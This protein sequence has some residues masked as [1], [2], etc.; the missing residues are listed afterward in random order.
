MVEIRGKA[1]GLATRITFALLSAVMVPLCFPPFGFW[2]L[3]LAVFALLLLAIRG[4]TPRQAFYLGMIHGTVGYGIA[5]HWFVFIFSALAFPLFG[6][7]GLFSAL[8][9]TLY[10]FVS[11]HAKNDGSKI[12]IAAVLWTGIEFYRSELFMLRFPWLTAGSALGPTFL[13]PILG[14]HGAT[15]LI[16]TAAAAFM[17]RTTLPLAF[18]LSLGVACLGIFRPGRVEPP[19]DA[20]TVAVVQSEECRLDSYLLLT[21]SLKEASPDLVIWPEY[22]LPYDVRRKPEHYVALKSLC[23]ELNT[24]LVVGTQTVLDSAEGGWHNTALTLD[25]GGTLGEYYKARPVHFFND[26]IPGRD[27]TPVQTPLGA[28]GTPICFDCDYSAVARKMA[29]LGAEFYAVPSFDAA[30]WS[31]YQHWQHAAMFRLRTAENG[32]WLACAASS[33]VSQIIDP[34][35]HVHSSLP[36]METGVIGCRIGRATGLTFFTRAGWVFPWLM[37]AGAVGLVVR[38]AILT[39]T[40]RSCSI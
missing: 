13:S 19:D 4:A 32:R 11:K 20:I 22:A 33:G 10:G 34:H 1:R 25:S 2:P 31:A 35:G 36:P 7:M 28:I 12:L 14:V 38:A 8:F 5:L 6:I 24:I 15:F 26:G 21:H 23:A 29:V 27:F 3:T 37:A 40:R 17:H 9:C 18:V 39:V 30:S 16:L